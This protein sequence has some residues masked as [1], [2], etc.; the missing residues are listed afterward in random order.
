MYGCD[1]GGTKTEFCVF[2]ETMNPVI[3]RRVP[4]PTSNYDRLLE[5]IRQQVVHADSQFG[6]ASTIGIGVPGIVDG[7]GYSY[8]VNV[9]CLSGRRVEADLARIHGPRVATINDGRAFALSEANGGAGQ[10]HRCMVGVILG[11][12]A[13]GGYCIEGNV[14]VGRD[15][16][17]GEWGHLP[18]A[19]TVLKRHDLPLFGCACGAVG[20]IECYVSGPGISRIH[21]H[22][23]GDS[24]SAEELVNGMRAGDP[25]C[26]RTLDI[27]LDCVATCFAQ[28]VLQINPDIIVIGGGLSGID[29]LYSHL[30]ERLSECLFEGVEP[31]PIKPA[32]FGASSGVRGAAILAAQRHGVIGNLPCEDHP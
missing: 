19:A 31:P 20:C 15:G 12:G 1:I 18:I 11:T 7:N 25:V 24:K 26:R 32:A 23:S 8:S 10:G 27:W 14:Q 3:T 4:T 2:D 17:A 21:N 29:T 16:V 6:R 22:I 28:L 30:P 13:F 5:T 9:P